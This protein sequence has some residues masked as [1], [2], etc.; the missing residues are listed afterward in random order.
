[1]LYI[2]T[3]GPVNIP[4]VFDN[5]IAKHQMPVTLGIFINPGEKPG[6]HHDKQRG[7]EY[8]KLNDTY[9]RFLLK[10]I[11]QE[12]SG[13]MPNVSRIPGFTASKG[14]LTAV[15]GTLIEAVAGK[16]YLDM[17]VANESAFTNS[18]EKR[19]YRKMLLNRYSMLL[20]L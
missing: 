20:K 17:E 9:A 4:T 12:L 3:K 5:L 16:R 13:R 15:D 19:I 8:T 10:D 18:R 6:V 1:L 7:L 11:I 2:D 14:V